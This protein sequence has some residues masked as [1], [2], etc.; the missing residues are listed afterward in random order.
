[1]FTSKG[2]ADGLR[3][4]LQYSVQLN[5]DE[6]SATAQDYA[7][8][9]RVTSSFAPPSMELPSSR[10]THHRHR[11]LVPALMA[12]SGFA[13]LVL[14]NPLRNA[15]CKALSIFSLCSD[16]SVLK[17]NVR[18][19]LQSQDTFDQSFRRVQEVKYEIPRR[20]F[21]PYETSSMPV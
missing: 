21:K 16:N 14:G 17:N 19:L 20:T 11:R 10:T 2:R 9:L 3:E 4:S 7:E 5:A 13:G 1:M 15:A 12:A 18:N 8:L 6:H